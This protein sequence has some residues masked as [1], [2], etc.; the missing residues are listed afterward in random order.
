MHVVLRREREDDYRAA[1]CV[2]KAAYWNTQTAGGDENYVAHV[3]RRSPAFVPELTYVAESDRGVIGSIMYSRAVI[4]CDD[5]SKRGVLNI[6]PIAVLPVLQRKGIGLRLVNFTAR[7]AA[8]AGHSAIVLYGEPLFFCKAGFVPAERYGI[9]TA[10]DAY[11]ACLLARE[12]QPGALSGCAGRYYE[13][14]VFYVSSDAAEAYDREFDSISKRPGLPA[15]R[16]FSELVATR[17][18]RHAPPVASDGTDK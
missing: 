1:E 11:T 13:D 16:R 15:Q 17:R 6:S 5:G 4:E 12:L 2:I 14:M 10:S 18:P 9:G 8:R 3:L 7:L